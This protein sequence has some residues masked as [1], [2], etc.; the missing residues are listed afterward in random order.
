[1][2]HIRTL[3]MYSWEHLFTQ[4]LME[5][6]QIEVKHLSVWNTYFN[7]MDLY[8]SVKLCLS[9]LTIYLLDSEVL[10]CLVCFFLGNNP[11]TVLLIYFWRLCTNGAFIRCCYSKIVL[12]CF[13][14]SCECK[15]FMS[16][17]ISS[18]GFYLCCTFQY[19]DLTFEFISMGD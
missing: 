18:A 4:R 3:K 10:G 13:V 6:R 16:L 14:S 15:Y 8:N 2:T 1:M 17:S 11:N 12:L 7:V 5:R 19:F 9:S